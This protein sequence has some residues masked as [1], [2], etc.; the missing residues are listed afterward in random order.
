[1]TPRAA[2]ILGLMAV[3][4]LPTSALTE[5]PQSEVRLENESVRVTIWKFQPGAGMGRHMGIEPEFG[6]VVEGELMLETPKGRETLRPGSVYWVPG[7]T[8]HDVRNGSSGSAM[9]WDV[10]LKRCQ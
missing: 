3:L 2:K 6:I 1:M 8:P 5:P 7:L 10:L 4:L 9:M